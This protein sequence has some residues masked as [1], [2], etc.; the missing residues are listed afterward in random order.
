MTRVLAQA[1]LVVI[2]CASAVAKLASD[3]QPYMLLSEA[4]YYCVAISE[5]VIA[6]GLLSK[7]G[8][9]GTRVGS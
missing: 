3:H 1:L 4:A 2:L 7:F 9:S 5:L 6:A 8:S